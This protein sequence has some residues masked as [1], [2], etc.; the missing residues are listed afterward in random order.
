MMNV[1]IAAKFLRAPKKLAFDQPKVAGIA[2]GAIALV[3][4][5]AFG[6]GYLARGAN[7][8]AL[9]EIA[10]MQS[11]LDAQALE[12][13]QAREEAQREVNAIAAR[14]GELQA[15][16]NR[17]NA[18]GD[19]LTRVGKLKDGEF[20]FGELPG[21]GGGETA[22]DIAAGDLLASLDQL[23]SQ[24]DHSGRQLDVLEALLFDQDVDAKRT[25]SGMPAPGYIV[26]GYGSRN[27]PFGRGR[28]HHMGIDID[29]NGGDPITSA[30][31]GVVSYSGWRNGYG[32]TIEIDH[33]NGFKTLY[34]HNAANL[35]KSGDVVRAGQLI[36]KVGSTGRSTGSHLHFEIKLDGRQVNPRQYL[37]RVRG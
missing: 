19:R 15:Q 28:A 29:A 35:V 9:Q 1:I 18:L 36:G 25:P 20:N 2:L 34:A 3:L 6:L 5:T 31:D 4:A 37:D 30:A 21:Q 22:G 10:R 17:L 26:S 14:V 33:G 11:Q 13:A 7:G 23:Q 16:A 24:F 27:D 32:N 8:A 12:L